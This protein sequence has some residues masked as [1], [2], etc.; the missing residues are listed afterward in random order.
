MNRLIVLIATVMCMALP[1]QSRA[2]DYCA[3]W[4]GKNP[5][6]ASDWD[7]CKEAGFIAGQVADLRDHKIA[8]K[9]VAIWLMQSFPSLHGISLGEIDRA[10]VTPVYESKESWRDICAEYTN[11]C[12]SNTP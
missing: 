6:P 1:A 3:P 12:E 4:A 9:D 7:Q 5:R 8:Q 10:Y 11:A 2:E